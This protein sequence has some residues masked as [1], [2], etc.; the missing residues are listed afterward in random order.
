MSE[1]RESRTRAVPWTVRMAMLTYG[2]IRQFGW[3]FAALG[4]LFGGV[5]LHFTALPFGGYDA[6]ATGEVVAVAATRS[7]V[8]EESVH[9][10]VVRFRGGEPERASQVTSYT[11]APPGVGEHVDVE[12]EWD[13][14]RQGRMT[15]AHDRRFPPTLLLVLLLPLIGT[16]VAMLRLGEGLRVVRLLRRGRAVKAKVIARGRGNQQVNKVYDTKLTFQFV[17]HQGAERTFD[18]STFSP[19]VLEDEAEELALYDPARPQQA[20]TL[21]H[22]PGGLK[23]HGDRVEATRPV[24]TLLILPGMAMGLAFAAIVSR[25]VW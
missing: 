19:E 18:V 13:D 24:G 6:H 9:E 17:D 2:A 12:Y 5:F 4:W 11:T 21:D 20:V 22:L 15:G 1:E 14:P 7:S 25:I 3:G 23:I 16:M 10:V 8:N